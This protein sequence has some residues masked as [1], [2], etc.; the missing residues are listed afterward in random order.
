MW[1]KRKRKEVMMMEVDVE[2]EAGVGGSDVGVWEEAVREAVRMG[3]EGVVGAGVVMVDVGHVGVGVEVVGVV[4]V[5]R[6]IGGWVD[7]WS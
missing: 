3:V 4:V 6:W 1:T 5:D 7:S 2:A